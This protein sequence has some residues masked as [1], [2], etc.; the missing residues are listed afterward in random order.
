MIARSGTMVMVPIVPVNGP[1]RGTLPVVPGM[2]AA[3]GVLGDA[4]A[5]GIME[6]SGTSWRR[7]IVAYG[8]PRT[9]GSDRQAARAARGVS[10]LQR[11]GRDHLCRESAGAARPRPQ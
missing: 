8:H 2:H 9:Q 6:G 4:D 7:V 11:G 1:R 5:A 3:R 10:V